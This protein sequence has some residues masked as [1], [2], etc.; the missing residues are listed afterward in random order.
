DVPK[1][2]FKRRC[3]THGNA[4]EHHGIADGNPNAA[5]GAEGALK[6]GNINLDGVELRHGIDKQTA[7]EQ[8][9]QHRSQADEPVFPRGNSVPLDDTHQGFMAGCSRFH[10]CSSFLRLVIRRPTSSLVV[11]RA[12]T[13]PLTLPAQST[14]IRSHSSKSTSKSSP[15]YT[16]AMP[17]I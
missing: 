5:A 6:H 12:S 7:E 9:H 4:Q 3:E 10:A 1:S 16:T 15:T 11:V 14:K 17:C 13:I 2:H 8:R